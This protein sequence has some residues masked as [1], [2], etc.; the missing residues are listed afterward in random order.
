MKRILLVLLLAACGA[1]TAQ[2]AP[3]EGISESTDPDKVRDVERRAEEI[4][5]RQQATSSGASDT[6]VGAASTTK[7]DAKRSKQKKMKRQ[8]APAPKAGS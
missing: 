6:S 8:P 4:R 7:R 1:A 2:N 5:S 3:L